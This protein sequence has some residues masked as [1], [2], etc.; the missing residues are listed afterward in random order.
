MSRFSVA[1]TPFAKAASMSV[2]RIETED[3]PIATRG[4][5]PGTSSPLL[6]DHQ[7]SSLTSHSVD[8]LG[9]GVAAV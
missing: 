2:S 3:V 4:S 9:H 5:P 8:G 1:T 7:I 6:Y